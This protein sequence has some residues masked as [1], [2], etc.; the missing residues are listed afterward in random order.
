V[1]GWKLSGARPFLEQARYWAWS[2]VPFV[3]LSPP[4]PSGIG[5]YATT[6]VLGATN[7][8]APVW[9]GLPVQWCG[10]VYSAALEDLAPL[11]PEGPWGVLARGIAAAGL[12][13]TWPES[14]AARRGLLPDVFFL[15]EQLRDGPAINPGT[16]QAALPGLFGLAPVY[17]FVRVD[18]PGWN[19]HAPGPVR[20]LDHGAAEFSFSLDGWGDRPY[21][22]LLSGVRRPPLAVDLLDSAGLAH[23]L[24]ESDWPI[25]S[26]EG[27]IVLRLKG[28]VHVRVRLRAD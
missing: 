26:E 28:S 8:T 11:D 21:H 20:D 7:W 2:G 17:E 13:M 6:P 15:R 3:Y 1:L 5:L 24:P 19:L 14:D 25:D 9:I 4:V 27:L 16:L 22:V 18:P 12:Q 23:P 10:L